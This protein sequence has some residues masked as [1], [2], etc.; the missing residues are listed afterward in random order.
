MTKRGRLIQKS[1]QEGKASLTNSGALLVKSG[2]HTGRC[3]EAKYIVKDEMTEG[4]VDWSSNQSMSEEEWDELEGLVSH[5]MRA[6]VN[7]GKEFH[8]VRAAAGRKTKWESRTRKTFKFICENTVQALFVQNMFEKLEEENLGSID[9]HECEV[10]CFPGAKKQATVAI[11][12]SKKIIIICGTSYLGEIKKSVFTYM[13]YILTDSSVLP[14]HCS[15]NVDLEGQ[16]P[17]VFFGLSG[18]GKTTLSSSPDRMLLGDDEHGWTPGVLFN[19]ES[20]CYAK[21]VGL[22]LEREPEIFKA[23]NKFGSILENVVSLDGEPDYDNSS[24]TKNGRA[25]YPLDHLENY[26]KTG[27]V[28]SDPKNVVMLTC[29]AF[30]VLPSVSRLSTDQ[31]REMFLIGY[32]SKVA[33]TEMGVTEPVATFSACFGAPFLPRDPNVYADL[34]VSFLERQNIDCWLVNTGWAGGPYGVGSRMDLSVTRTIIKSIVDGT[35]SKQS[36]FLHRPTGLQIPRIIP[37]MTSFDTRPERSWESMS[38]Y[39]EQAKILMSLIEK[40]KQ[41]FK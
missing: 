15:V 34:L 21:T 27:T 31:A 1:L 29:D 3:P 5:Y 19:I 10:Y 8:V 33:G 39:N 13:N 6:W 38:S 23:A 18:T 41:K 14:M 37:Q 7:H 36:F 22:S 11:N 25:S 24:I 26:V 20:G 9:A 17:A 12:F 4:S 2:K 40:E 30:G 32:T 28:F 35:M 16:N